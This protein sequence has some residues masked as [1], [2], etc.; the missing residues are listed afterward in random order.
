MLFLIRRALLALTIAASLLSQGI[1]ASG[2]QA[3]ARKRSAAEEH[4]RQ[5]LERDV[6]YI[7]SPEEKAVFLKLSTAEEKDKFIEQFWL[8]RDPDRSTLGNEF[9]DEHYRRMA[10]VNKY[11]GSGIP[12]WKTDRGKIYILHGEPAQIES[13]SGGSY[14]R[15]RSEGGGTTATF[16]FEVWTYRHIDGIG[17]DIRIEFV[18]K[19]MTGKYT[20]AVDASEKDALLRIPGL[21]KTLLEEAGAA[22]K[23]D[24]VLGINQQQPFLQMGKS[25]KDL[26]FE[27]LAQNADL[28][29]PQ[30]IRF[31]ELQQLIT[32]KVTYLS[33]IHI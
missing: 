24:R 3:Q 30:P 2:A 10:Y 32:A 25:V 15:S 17:D 18:D 27:R 19:T 16:P 33:L 28:E 11:F 12:G 22:S 29:K 6:V 8:R 5:W 21:G 20:I 13:H 14:Q 7:I 23:T 31:K 9:K 1:A 26:P 4:Y